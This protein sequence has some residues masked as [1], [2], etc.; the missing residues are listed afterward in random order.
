ME[1][2][3]IKNQVAKNI[4]YYRKTKGINQTK[5]AEMLNTKQTV[6]SRYETG[7]LELDYEK[8][9]AICEILEITPN[10]IFEDCLKNK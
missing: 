2:T 8:I 3:E 9:I 4:K 10:E 1:K 5:I 6:Y 7:K